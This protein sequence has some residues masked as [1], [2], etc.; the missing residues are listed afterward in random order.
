MYLF[1]FSLHNNT[2]LFVDP[3]HVIPIK[4][5]DVCGYSVIKCRISDKSNVWI[6][7]SDNCNILV[8]TIWLD[9]K[10]FFTYHPPLVSHLVLLIHSYSKDID[11]VFKVYA[12][13]PYDSPYISISSLYLT[14]IKTSDDNF[15]V[16]IIVWGWG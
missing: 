12:W 6:L 11:A 15:Q 8:N 16:C 4:Y 3:W 13:W 14:I 10:Q 5:V 2:L 7:C 1:F 9:I